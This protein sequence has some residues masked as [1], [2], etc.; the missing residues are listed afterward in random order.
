[1]SNLINPALTDYHPSSRSA[2]AGRSKL[3]ARAVATIG[4]TSAP[5][6][7]TSMPSSAGRSGARRRNADAGLLA[8]RPIPSPLIQSP[9]D[10]I[11][12]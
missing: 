4:T 11:A 5:R 1:M 10:S 8:P 2:R 7:P 6:A 12:P 9:P 3:L